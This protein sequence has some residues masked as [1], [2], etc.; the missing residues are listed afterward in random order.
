VFPIEGRDAQKM[1]GLELRDLG[2]EI[3]D[4]VVAEIE[5]EVVEGHDAP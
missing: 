1:R 5:A 4:E 2:P 3:E